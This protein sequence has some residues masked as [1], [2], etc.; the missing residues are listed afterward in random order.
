MLINTSK[1]QGFTLFELMIVVMLMGLISGIVLPRLAGSLSA[2][3][4]R[5]SVKQTSAILRYARNLAVNDQKVWSVKFDPTT[6]KISLLP[7]VDADDGDDGEIEK[8]QSFEKKIYQLPL[9]VKILK[10]VTAK[11]ERVSNDQSFEVFFYP[12]GSCSGGEIFLTTER[13]GI[14]RISVGF[15]TGIVHAR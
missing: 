15:P 3:K 13:K 14:Y 10:M 11:G 1:I 8:R 2:S 7:S 9:E 6:S 4:V 12:A 5:T